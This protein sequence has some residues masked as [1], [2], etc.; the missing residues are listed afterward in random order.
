MF[1]DLVRLELEDVSQGATSKQ[2]YFIMLREA[3][4][5]RKLSVIVGPYEAQA[6]LTFMRKIPLPR[7][8]LH[9]SMLASF[10]AFG[11]GLREVVIHKVRDGVFYSKMVLVREGV[12]QEVDARTSDAVAMALRYDAPIFTYERLL[13]RERVYEN[14]DGA[15]SIPV[16]SLKAELLREALQRA[17]SEENYELAAQ[18]RDELSR[19]EKEE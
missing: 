13:D 3:G 6:I 17:I 19:R 16:S 4:G 10:M 5:A 14:A 9:D 8:L 12:I 2:A 1:E 7:P 11:I 18:L 15:I